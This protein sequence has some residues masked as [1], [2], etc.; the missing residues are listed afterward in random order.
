MGAMIWTAVPIWAKRAASY[1]T[2]GLIRAT[3]GAL[4]LGQLHQLSFPGLVGAVSSSCSTPTIRAAVPVGL[5]A[6][7]HRTLGLIRATLFGLGL[8]QLR[9]LGFLF[10]KRAVSSSWSTARESIVW[11]AEPICHRAASSRASSPLVVRATRV[12]LG[13]GQL[14]HQLGLLYN[15]RAVSS[16]CSTI[17]SIR[18]AVPVG[19]R[20][21]STRAV[22]LIGATL[23]GL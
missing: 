5:W 2:C 17:I 7:V 6:A 9:Q 3:L 15:K 19:P 8:G 20:A 14:H 21:A 13:L 11:T 22:S 23:L 16:S 12:G 1:R 4:G 18:A 10:N